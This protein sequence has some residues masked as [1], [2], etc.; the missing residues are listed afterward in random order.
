ME[1]WV[2]PKKNPEG[3]KN[4]SDELD[5]SLGFRRWAKCW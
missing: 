4:L 3:K 1:P 2:E 5:E